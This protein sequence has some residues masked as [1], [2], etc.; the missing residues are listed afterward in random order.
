MSN[1]DWHG[2]PEFAITGERLGAARGSGVEACRNLQWD[3]WR[4][5]IAALLFGAV[6]ALGLRLQSAGAIDLP[7]PIFLMMP[8][9]VTIVAMAVLARAARAP[10][11]L[12][13]PF[14]K[15]ER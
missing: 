12:L 1:G 11:A 9:V 10:A 8:F 5:A 4:C 6:E 3:P 14:R 13:I 7:Y 2:G 15:E